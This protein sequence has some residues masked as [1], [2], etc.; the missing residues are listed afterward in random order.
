MSE[1]RNMILAAGLA[2]AILFGFNYL[3]EQPKNLERMQQLESLKA[4]ATEQKTAM[5]ER[6][7]SIPSKIVDE[8][9]K[10]FGSRSEAL[11]ATKRIK[12]N[13]PSLHGSIN[14]IGATLDDLTLAQYHEKPDTSS[15]EIILLSPNRVEHAYF[16]DFGWLIA[17]KEIEL[18]NKNSEWKVHG[19]SQFQSLG[20]VELTPSQPLTLVWFN[21]SGLRFEKILTVDE[22][23]LFTIT[24]R[25]V[26]NGDVEVSMQPYGQVTRVGTPTTSGFFILHEGPIGVFNSRLKELDYSKLIKEKS[27]EQTTTGGWLGFTDK[28]WLVALLPDQKL[29]VQTRFFAETVG[30]VDVYNCKTLSPIQTL[31]PGQS[32]ESKQ[33]LFAGAKVLRILDQYEKKFGFSRF[34]LAVDFGWFYFLTKPLF[35]VLEFFH[36]F[37]GNFGLAILALTVLFK[38]MFL[39][40]AN[41]SYRSMSRMKLLQP[42]IEKIKA[43]V[44]DDKIKLNTEMMALYKKEKINPMGGCLPMLIQAPIFF[45]LYKVFFVTIEMRHAPFYGWINDLSSPDPTT[46]FNLFGLIPWDPP[47]ML[48]IGVWPLIMG[49]TMILQQRLN[50]QPADPMQA[51]MMMLMPIFFTYLLASF[52]AGLVI[53]WAWNNILSMGQQ[54]FISTHG[55]G[56]TSV[57]VK[58]K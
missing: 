33:N 28:Y 15:Q 10:P 37:L 9:K 36:E 40:L 22:N 50:P 42:Q 41:K 8:I 6:T 32:I 27:A 56:Q 34:D 7:S 45:C 30:G 1:Q 54:W 51:K 11:Q 25:V 29:P 43:R 19:L 44:G 52:P 49:A 3:Y 2:F 21:G 39:P 18:P 31:K 4:Q 23:Y 5:P 13:T 12:I 47:S 46:I 35:Y 53:Y 17:E 55:A 57:K 14:L 48:M 16:A 24:D 26:N 20:S 58:G 38:I